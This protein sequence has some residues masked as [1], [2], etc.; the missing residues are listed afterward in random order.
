MAVE[1]PSITALKTAYPFP[2][3]LVFSGGQIPGQVRRTA[4]AWIHEAIANQAGQI[5]AYS[6]RFVRVGLAN[7]QVTRIASNLVAHEFT[8]RRFEMPTSERIAS[9]KRKL[10]IASNRA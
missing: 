2:W 8:Q 9:A 5:E 6:I 10:R 7:K 3:V 4:L 1:R